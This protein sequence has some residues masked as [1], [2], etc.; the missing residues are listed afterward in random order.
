MKIR[1]T[2][3]KKNNSTDSLFELIQSMSATEK[4]YVN[5]QVKHIKG[6]DGKELDYIILFKIL[7]K[8]EE[9]DEE[10]AKQKLLKALNKEKFSNF[11]VKKKELYEVLMRQLKNFHYNKMKK[12]VAYIKELINDAVFLFRR[13]LYHQAD[14]YLEDAKKMAEKCGDTLS[15][16]EIN[17]MEREFLR[18]NR[19]IKSEEQVEEFHQIEKG[20]I[21][22]LEEE[23]GLIRDCDTLSVKVHFK[24]KITTQKSIKKIKDEF[25][26][27]K[28][29]D[30]KDLTIVG[31]RFLLSGLVKY[32]NLIGDNEKLLLYVEAVFEWW[33]TNMLWKNQMPHYYIAALTNALSSYNRSKE[34][35]KYPKILRILEN[36]ETNTHHE[37]TIKF[38]TLMLYRQLYYMNVGLIDEACNLS[39][40]IAKG[41]KTYQLN[42][43][44]QVILI[45]NTIVAFFFNDNYK[46]CL[47]WA[48]FFQP[49][50]I[51][52]GRL[53]I[54]CTQIFKLISVNEIGIKSEKEII[55]KRI[56]YFFI[57]S[58]V[59]KED[60]FH[61]VIFELINKFYKMEINERH[62]ILSEINRHI[63]NIQ[64]DS[65]I[66]WNNGL[67][68]LEYWRKSKETNQK[69]IKLVIKDSIKR[70]SSTS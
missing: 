40:P 48:N 42:I 8:M 14:K 6:K 21:E 20:L 52:R 50:M 15:L 58:L 69:M 44:T 19:N 13:G 11:S 12:S 10:K 47:E 17:R 34:Y 49:E 1:Q 9:Y 26:D 27:L 30:D 23:T 53:E 59:I 63:H 70:A 16:I 2:K 41:L 31:K 25:S 67:E 57:N 64:N 62:I 65:Q 43:R 51:E 28:E 33:E 68:E 5:V 37:A 22:N 45:Y 36:I 18:A 29:I 24:N 55:Y 3:P 38:Q 4:R 39:I 32:Y 54:K 7:N 66:T 46:K 61:L 60:D 56:K 35:N